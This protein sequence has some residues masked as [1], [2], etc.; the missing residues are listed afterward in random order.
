[1]LSLIKDY[2]ITTDTH[3]FLP[4]LSNIQSYVPNC[5]QIKIEKRAKSN[6]VLKM[7]VVMKIIFKL[8]LKDHRNIGYLLKTKKLSILKSNTLLDVTASV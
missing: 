6:I 7:Q 1:M 5:L 8:R 4:I 3:A 2:T